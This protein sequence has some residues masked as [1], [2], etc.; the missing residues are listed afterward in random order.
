MP[1][2]NDGPHEDQTFKPDPPEK[3]KLAQVVMLFIYHIVLAFVLAYAIYNVWP[4]QPWPGDRAKAPDKGKSSQ[5]ANTNT[6]KS[7]TNSAGGTKTSA[8]PEGNSNAS[9]AGAAGSKSG[10][11]NTA[12]DAGASAT[13]GNANTTGASANTN[14]STSAANQNSADTS[15]NVYGDELPPAFSLFG[16]KFQPTLEVRLLL[17][18]LLAG[19]IGSYVHATS[20]FVDYL[21]NRTL[22]S[23]WVWWYLLRPYIGMMLALLFYF[24]FRGGFITAGVNQGGSD[25][26]S[27][28]NPF[29]IAAM[30]GLVGM[31]SKVAADKLNEVFLTLFQPKS[32]QGDANR[33]DKLVAGIVPSVAALAPNTG[34]VAGGTAVT[35]SGTGFVAGVIVTFGDAPATTV[36]VKNETTL[37]VVTPP[38]K[39][40]GKV[41]V[42]VTNP[43]KQSFV[44]KGG[45]TYE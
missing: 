31:F 16:K 39:A 45:F 2:Q 29:G 43:N 25:A 17:L 6:N 11:T 32:G 38:G 22:I 15:A 4:P 12:A 33:G 28:I 27:F 30:G 44:L 24:V 18:V 20:S 5:Q 34:P 35:L 41:D 37:T 23:S 7:E 13:T 19:A 8:S 3:V 1:T 26:A 9:A 40:P 36:A 10:N 42:N 14:S 21:G